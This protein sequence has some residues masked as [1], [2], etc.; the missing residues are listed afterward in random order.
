M[1]LLATSVLA[2]AMLVECSEEQKPPP[3]I[4]AAPGHLAALSIH[5]QNATQQAARVA[6]ED[7]SANTV[8]LRGAVQRSLVRAGY[9]VVVSPDEPRDL[10]ARVSAD[11]PW[12][13]P[14][15]ATL[16]FVDAE[17]AMVDQISGL[18]VFDEEHDIDERS[19]VQLVQAMA[20]SPKLARFARLRQ[21]RGQ[22]PPAGPKPAPIATDRE[23]PDPQ[24]GQLTGPP[25]PIPE[26]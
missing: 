6:E 2:V 24:P 26:R 4:K 14:G 17:G 11:W 21:Q 13:R 3:P 7:V 1:R 19:A 23:P 5:V 25:D 18:V 9:R 22:R 8:Y 12:D 20:H 10:T 15:T 16:S